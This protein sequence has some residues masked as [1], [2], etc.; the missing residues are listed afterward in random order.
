MTLSLLGLRAELVAV[1]K[2][3]PLPSSIQ[4]LVVVANHCR[5]SIY[6]GYLDIFLMVGSGCVCLASS[7]K[8]TYTPLAASLFRVHMCDIIAAVTFRRKLQVVRT[9]SSDPCLHE[10]VV[11][12]HFSLALFCPRLPFFLFAS[13]NYTMHT[14]D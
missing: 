14:F 7:S 10:I 13:R 11:S 4:L 6:S 8:S 9:V 12:P 5:C 2:S 1:V 3:Q